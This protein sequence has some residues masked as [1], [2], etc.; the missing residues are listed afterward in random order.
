MSVGLNTTKAIVKSILEKYPRTRNSDSYLYLKVIQHFDKEY[1]TNIQN[2]TVQDFLNNMYDGVPIPPF[3]SV[4][5][6]RQK[7]QE[8]HP[9]LAACS[10]VQLLRDLNEDAYREFAQGGC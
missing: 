2:I 1:C 6:S 7:L 10:E 4:R 3:E 9:H 5:R 8:E